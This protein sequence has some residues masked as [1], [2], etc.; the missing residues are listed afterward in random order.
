M[1]IS[2][3]SL[4]RFRQAERT[5]RGNLGVLCQLIP[6]KRV[7]DL[8]L[9]LAEMLKD[10]DRFHL[11][12]GGADHP[13]HGDYSLALRR[14]VERL[15]I[16]DRV[17][18]Y[19]NVEDTPSWLEKIDVFISHSYSEGLQVAPIKAM[20]T[21]CYTLVH[22]W[23]GAEEMVPGDCIYLTGDELK[24]RLRAYA[25]ASEEEKNR[26]QAR[27]RSIACEQFDAEESRRKFREVIDE[28]ASGRKAG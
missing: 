14:I 10:G 22:G 2:S 4:D 16:Q 11:H 20:A 15:G 6:R 8:I 21:G 13:A 9:V 28:L 1:I 19:G 17:T 25:A 26:Q 7:Y 5:Y 18:F 3:V 12:I 27:M 24:A 23:N